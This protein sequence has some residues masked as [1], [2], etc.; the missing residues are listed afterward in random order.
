MDWNMATAD[1]AY[2]A[3]LE[4]NG[5][6]LLLEEQKPVGIATCIRFG[7]V[8]WF[9]NLII[10]PPN[11]KKGAGSMLVQH[12]VDY[13]H[14][15]GVET[16]GLYAYPHLKEFY[17]KIGFKADVDFAL[18]KAD[19]IA[20]IE[21]SG[22]HRIE[23]ENLPRIAAFDSLFFGS[24]RTQLIESIA[25][26]EGN[27]G[28]YASDRGHVV[29][30]A[31][32]TIYESMAWLGPLTCYPGRYDILGKLVSSILAKTSGRT[33]YTVAPKTDTVL[34]DLFASIG[35]KEEFTVTRMFNGANLAKNCIYL[36]E[37]LERG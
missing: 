30:F 19:K 36:A 22:V 13:L 1:F 2:M 25:L 21:A 34:L 9:G 3:S 33:V 8:G 24:D 6:F 7:K 27:T 35:F 17:G 32:A 16:I 5:S 28:Y 4:P 31:A 29:G 11:R 15:K 12:A 37:S 14:A 23:E 20:P 18:L 10:D 26:E